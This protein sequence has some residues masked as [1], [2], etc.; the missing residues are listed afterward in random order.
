MER[1]RAANRLAAG[2]LG[3][4]QTRQLVEVGYSRSTIADRVAHGLWQRIHRGVIYLGLGPVTRESRWLAAVLA[5]GDDAALAGQAAA[6]HLGLIRWRAPTIEVMT[7]KSHGRLHR[8]FQTRRTRRWS[9][10]DRVMHARIPT[11]S[12]TRCII[13]LTRSLDAY[14]LVGIIDRAVRAFRLDVDRLQRRGRELRH[15]C[16]YPEFVVALDQYRAGSHGARSSREVRLA[17][18]IRA[19]GMPAPQLNVVVTTPRGQYMLDIS[20]P[21]YRCLVEVDDH[22]HDQPHMRHQDR[23]RELGLLESGLDVM[24]VPNEAIDQ[25]LDEVL[26]RIEL[27]LRRHGW[28]GK[29]QA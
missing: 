18:A 6:Q 27:L 1:E 23:N 28:R 9:P 12:P 3:L 22:G 15:A 11:M 5:V 21:G 2:Q 20:W 26:D 16:S 8:G 17:R 4:A 14:E 25:M 29:R 13:D 7:S 19:A 10:A 24:R